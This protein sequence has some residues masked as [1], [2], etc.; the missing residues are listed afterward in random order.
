[1]T[2][3]PGYDLRF[4]ESLESNMANRRASVERNT[5]ETQISI[6]VDLDGNG[7]ADLQTG[8]PFFGTHAGSGR[9]SRAD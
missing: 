2:D 4:V 8:I 5:R 6:E 1:L 3:K 9:A 7:K